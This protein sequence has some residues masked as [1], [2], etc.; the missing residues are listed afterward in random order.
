MLLRGKPIDAVTAADWGLVARVFEDAVLLEEV[1]AIAAEIGEAP[2]G[3]VAQSK[4]LLRD[5]EGLGVEETMVKE[6]EVLASRYGSEENVAAVK[7]FL[8]ARMA[9][10]K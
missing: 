7:A 4:A 8:A 3:A 1:L 10:K 9:R 2:P 5:T 6:D